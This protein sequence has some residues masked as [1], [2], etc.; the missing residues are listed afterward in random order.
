MQ[1]AYQELCEAKMGAELVHHVM[2]SLNLMN[3]EAYY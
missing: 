2:K 1:R 3:L